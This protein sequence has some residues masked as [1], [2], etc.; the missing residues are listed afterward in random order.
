MEAVGL[1]E[2]DK[3]PSFLRP[4]A[5]AQVSHIRFMSPRPDG[6]PVAHALLVSTVANPLAEALCR[7]RRRGYSSELTPSFLSFI[8]SPHLSLSV[9]A[10]S[11]KNWTVCLFMMFSFPSSSVIQLFFPS[12]LLHFSP[13]I[14]LFSFSVLSLP[15]CFLSCVPFFIAFCLVLSLHFPTHLTHLL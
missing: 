4:S 2:G 10:V 8:P 1:R 12:Y 13:V 5:W 3:G 11:P 15:S 6:S 9:K 14:S 7:Y